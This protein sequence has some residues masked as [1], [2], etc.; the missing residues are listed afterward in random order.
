[1]SDDNSNN[2]G[3]AVIG[4]AGRFPGAANVEQF[5]QNLRDGVESISFFTERE[6]L[7]S[8]IFPERVR[9]PNYVNARGILLANVFPLSNLCIP[10]EGYTSLVSISCL[11]L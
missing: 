3:I 1:M 10:W 11:H 8:T 7:A 2:T 5:W 6:M 9:Q 4:M